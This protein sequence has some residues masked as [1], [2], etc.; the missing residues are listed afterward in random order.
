VGVLAEVVGLAECLGKYKR[1]GER[2]P[3]EL[4]NAMRRV[5][6]AKARAIK[7]AMKRKRT[8]LLYKSVGNKTKEGRNGRIVDVAGA[9]RGFRVK[10]TGEQKRKLLSV[11][12]GA[13]RP[14]KGEGKKV[15]LKKARGVKAG[16]ALDPARYAH[17]AD[18]GHK[19]G[20]GKGAAQGQHFMAAADKET[21]PLA[22]QEVTSALKAIGKA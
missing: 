15:V 18:Q 12:Q 1:M 19:K 5:G 11:K 20:K 16:D 21:R 8:G 10:V 13:K 6:T 7:K 2:A 14:A 17:L 3:R 22:I 4:R 9:R